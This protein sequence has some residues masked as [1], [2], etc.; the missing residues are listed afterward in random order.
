MQARRPCRRALTGAW[1]RDLD[2]DLDIIK[3]WGASL[4]LTLVELHE[5]EQLR[6]ARMGDAV[7]IRGMQWL[8][9]PIKDYHPPSASFEESWV[10]HGAQIR[11]LLRNG[12]DILVHCKGGLGRAGMIAAR[13]LVELGVPPKEAINSVRAARKD[14][15]ETADQEDI[16]RQTKAIP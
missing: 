9:L 11:Q 14:A 13:P 1:R 12:S 15:I 7:R 16:A 6:V 10:T 8:H 4:I 5:L 3:D 2:I